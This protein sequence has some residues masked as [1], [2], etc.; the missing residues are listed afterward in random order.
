MNKKFIGI[1]LF[2]F[3][4][5]F[6]YRAVSAKNYLIKVADTAATQKND[7]GVTRARR[8]TNRE[9]NAVFEQN[10]PLSSAGQEFFAPQKTLLVA[11]L[12]PSFVLINTPKLPFFF[13]AN[14]RVNLRL[15]ASHG[16]PVKSPSYMPGGTLYF[17][18]NRD[19]YH[20][21][22]LSLAYTH[23]SNGI[24]GP[25]L[26]PNGTPNTDSG[27]FT[28]NFYTLTYHMGKRIDINNRIINRYDAIGLELHAY[29]VGLGYAY[30]LKG[31]YGFVR[32]NG[33][34]LYNIAHANSDPVDPEKKVYGNWQRF[35]FQ[36]T[37]IADKVYNYDITD[38]K[39]RLNV[40]LKYYYQFPFMQNVSFL[41]GIGYRGQDEYNIFFRD[42]YAYVTV[43][44]AAGLSFNMRPKE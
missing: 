41:G 27:K 37:Y 32:V 5:L 30:P 18:T 42:S 24:E 14:A 40:S 13:V 26:Y 3:F 2:G 35:D 31:K 22:F 39:K 1:I 17:R 21:Q 16:D 6:P 44:L 29:I 19:Y 20:P 43:G 33:Q 23:H 28:T 36:F 10:L 34:W 38:I 4:Y 7:T 9:F 15:F 12:S 8:I 11:D 25:T